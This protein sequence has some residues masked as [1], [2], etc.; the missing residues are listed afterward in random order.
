MQIDYQVRSQ[1][2]FRH[3]TEITLP[4]GKLDGVINWCK[5]ALE[6]EWR[7]QLREMSSDIRP[8]RYIFY[9]DSE[10]DYCAFKL[11]WS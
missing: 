2:S 10:R 7:W 9:F 6:D 11:C 5:Q 8:G 3:A 4:F 1:E